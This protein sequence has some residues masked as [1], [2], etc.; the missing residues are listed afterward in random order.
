MKLSVLGVS[1]PFTDSSTCTGVSQGDDVCL[2][3]SIDSKHKTIEQLFK[4]L[5]Y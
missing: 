5:D 4:S 3:L 1:T 2:Y